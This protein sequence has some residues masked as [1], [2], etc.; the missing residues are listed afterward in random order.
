M[1]Q[2]GVELML[3]VNHSSFRWS[4]AHSKAFVANAKEF[5]V[6][7]CVL[8]LVHH[9]EGHYL[10]RLWMETC[11]HRDW[12]LLL[13]SRLHLNW[14]FAG[15]KILL[16][17]DLA[18]VLH[19][20]RNDFNLL[21]LSWPIRLLLL[22]RSFGGALDIFH[23]DLSARNVYFLFLAP[24]NTFSVTNFNPFRIGVCGLIKTAMII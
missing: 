6:L 5:C 16:R 24:S 15:V 11:L 13:S 22:T 7:L 20:K 4:Q 19:V 17:S 21:L 3:M 8:Y 23:L 12:L 14:H 2:W 18:I 9:R 1:L 10:R